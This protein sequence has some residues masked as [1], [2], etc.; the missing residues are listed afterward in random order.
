MLPK[1]SSEVTDSLRELGSPSELAERPPNPTSQ[2][3]KASESLSDR[4]S[5]HLKETMP[6]EIRQK[7]R[8]S[9]DHLQ[10]AA[11]GSTVLPPSARTVVDME[12]DDNPTSGK[13]S[14]EAEQHKLATPNETVRVKRSGSLGEIE[15]EHETSPGV[16]NEYFKV[17]RDWAS[18]NGTQTAVSNSRSSSKHDKR[19][20]TGDASMM[21]KGGNIRSQ[22]SS[23][24]PGLSAVVQSTRVAIPASDLTSGTSKRTVLKKV[25]NP[26]LLKHK[27]KRPTTTASSQSRRLSEPSASVNPSEN[28]PKKAAAV[29]AANVVHASA[30]KPTGSVAQR[31]KPPER[32]DFSE[33]TGLDVESSIKITPARLST[34]VD[35]ELSKSEI[36]T[37]R[38][39]IMGPPRPPEIAPT[40]DNG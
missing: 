24:M 13:G 11:Y 4:F 12:G 33:S 22:E 34:S 30:P 15:Q 18:P 17:S 3:T 28:H 26:S 29:P 25:A 35:T 27:L 1:P 16:V 20:S 36:L 40:D 38:T 7:P 14:D 21:F 39:M 31:E 32:K 37:E 5:V 9:K 8:S 19:K 6:L 10:K 23:A 2:P